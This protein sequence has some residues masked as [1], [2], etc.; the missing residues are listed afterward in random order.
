MRRRKRNCAGVNNDFAPL[1]ISLMIGSIGCCRTER[2]NMFRLPAREFQAIQR[3][4]FFKTRNCC[5]RSFIRTTETGQKRLLACHNW[6]QKASG[7]KWISVFGPVR[8]KPDGLI[9][10]AGQ[11]MILPANIWDNG[12]ACATSLSG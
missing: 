10:P 12:P 11:S 6:D 5:M 3:A 4:N 7:M 9:M 2:W 1:P 8:E